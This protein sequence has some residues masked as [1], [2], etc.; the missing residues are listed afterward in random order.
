MN[1]RWWAN[2]GLAVLI[3]ALALVMVFRPGK[4]PAPVIP[5]LTGLAAARI[6][7]IRLQRPG[8]PEIDLA[9]SAGHWIMTAPRRA[10]AN[11]FRVNELLHL[12]TARLATHFTA[13]VSSLG[14]YGLDKPR[15]VVW[16]D[17]EKISFGAQHPIDPDYYALYQGQVYLVPDHY[18]N[19]ATAPVAGFFSTSLVGTHRRLMSLRLPHLHLARRPDGSW[20]VTP[21]DSK[22]S[23]DQVNTFV[24]DWRYAEALSVKPYS[25]RPVIGHIRIRFAP[26]TVSGLPATGHPPGAHGPQRGPVLVLGILERK[27]ELV[28]YRS[29]EGLEYHF[30]A[31]MASQLL[32]LKPR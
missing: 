4:H 6:V 21:P 18:V 3:A 12:A 22:L 17:N 26:R 2:A 13:P 27:P 1:S 7:H 31:D 29:D 24:D 10:R 30:P 20:Q 25:G 28:L 14:K 16:L 9:K 15:A 32:E 11:S 8:E 23:T 5:P 19:A